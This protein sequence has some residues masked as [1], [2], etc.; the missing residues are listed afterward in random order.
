VIIVISIKHTTGSFLYIDS[1][2]LRKVFAVLQF[3]RNS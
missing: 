2:L 3:P 1:L